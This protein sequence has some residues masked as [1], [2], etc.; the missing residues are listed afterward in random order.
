M[1]KRSIKSLTIAVIGCFYAF[2]ARSAVSLFSDYGQIQNVQNYSTN[3][4]W[5]PNAPYNQRVAPQPVYVQGNNVT[6][7]ECTRVIQSAVAF[8]C[9]ARDNCRNT[10]LADIRPAIVVQLSNLPNKAYGTACIGY[11]D[12][13]YESYVAQ[14]G[15]NAP[16]Q[17]TNF[18]N[19]AVPNPLMNKNNSTQIKNPYEIKTPQWQQEINDRTQ[20]LQNLQRQNGTGNEALSATDFPA[21]YADLSFSERMQNNAAGYAPWQGKSAYNTINIVHQDEWCANHQ[22]SPECRGNTTQKIQ[23]NT[24][25]GTL[26]NP[27]HNNAS[28]TQNTPQQNISPSGVIVTTKENN[29]NLLPTP[30]NERK[31]SAIICENTGYNV[32]ANHNNPNYNECT[33]VDKNEGCYSVCGQPGSQD[34][35]DLNTKV[36][37]PILG[38]AYCVNEADYTL[39]DIKTGQP[40]MMTQDQ[41]NKIKT[42]INQYIVEKGHCSGNEDDIDFFYGYYASDRSGPGTFLDIQGAIRLDD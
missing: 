9:S 35:D 41:L 27:Q 33:N 29:Q 19:G 3:P 11:L 34:S 31:Y 21:T 4:F 15:N 23:Q 17:R 13:V 36:F 30:E 20:E 12:T 38:S 1:R 28:G 2:V 16:T 7:E 26:N 40:L 39:H 22:N 6:G 8:Q 14:F 18:P 32:L 37:K 10:T 25:Y 5:S 24:T 42:R